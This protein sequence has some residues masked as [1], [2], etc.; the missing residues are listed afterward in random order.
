MGSTRRN[1]DLRLKLNDVL[2]TPN[3][4]ADDADL[5]LFQPACFFLCIHADTDTN[6]VG[7]ILAKYLQNISRPVTT[8]GPVVDYLYLY[9]STPSATSAALPHLDSLLDPIGT[10]V[11]TVD[12]ELLVLVSVK[13]DVPGG[14]AADIVSVLKVV[15]CRHGTDLET[16]ELKLEREL[17]LL[18]IEGTESCCS[19]R[20]IKSS[21]KNVNQRGTL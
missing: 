18:R 16:G 1:D 15:Y 14:V 4:G 11:G 10:F 20:I 13:V 2:H 12:M 21:R 9:F 19:A 3:V 5:N 17:F 7:D 8:L 6:A